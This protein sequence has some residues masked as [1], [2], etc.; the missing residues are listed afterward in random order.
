MSDREFLDFYKDVCGVLNMEDAEF[1]ERH[2]ELE[3]AIEHNW[4]QKRYNCWWQDPNRKPNLVSKTYISEV[5]AVSLKTVDDWERKGAPIHQKGNHGIAY[6]I[7]SAAFMEW[8]F[9]RESGLTIAEYREQG[10]EQA[11]R[12]RERDEARWQL[13]ETTHEN[14]KLATA[15]RTLTKELA[16]LRREVGALKRAK[17]K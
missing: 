1:I 10:L 8:Y 6:Q 17:A 16:S 9:A 2:R 13:I 11:I 12:A 4:D 5:M 3:A 7:D 15:V 14:R